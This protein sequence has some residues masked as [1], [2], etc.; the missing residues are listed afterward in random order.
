MN[1]ENQRS[2]SHKK[3]NYAISASRMDGMAAQTGAEPSKEFLELVKKEINGEITLDEMI[4]NLIKK[5]TDVGK[6]YPSDDGEADKGYPGSYYFPGTDILINKFGI[7]DAAVL[8]QAELEVTACRMAQLY[9][10]NPGQFTEQ[11][12]DDA[13]KNKYDPDTI[14]ILTANEILNSEHYLNITDTVSFIQFILCQKIREFDRNE[15]TPLKQKLMTAIRTLDDVMRQSPSTSS[16]LYGDAY[17]EGHFPIRLGRY[18]HFKGGEYDVLGFAKHTDTLETLVIYREFEEKPDYNAS[19]KSDI[20][21][22]PLSEWEDIIEIDGKTVKR[23]E[24]TQPQSRN[25]GINVISK[26]ENL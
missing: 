7:R 14:Q 17:Y 20:W 24:Y 16:T 19:V 15:D 2:E 11:G 1:T 3:W 4:E 21:A 10:E 18:K 13:E 23:F 26:G 25:W 12:A 5:W 22:R 6:S 9:M 8:G